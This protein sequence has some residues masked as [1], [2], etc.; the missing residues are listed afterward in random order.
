MT[1][2]GEDNNNP[3][4]HPAFELFARLHERNMAESQ[5]IQN[6]LM[7]QKDKRIAELEEENE[8]LRARLARIERKMEALLY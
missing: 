8:D 1:M 6:W 7:E 2:P 3:F 4:K 5:D